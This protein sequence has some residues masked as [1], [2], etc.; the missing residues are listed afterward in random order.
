MVARLRWAGA[1]NKCIGDDTKAAARQSPNCINKQKWNKIWRKR[2]SIWRMEL[3][4][5]ATWHD[6]D[7]DFARWLH[8]FHLRI[9][10]ANTVRFLPRDAMQARPMPSCGVCVSVCVRHISYILSKRINISSIFV[11]HSSFSVTKQH[12]NIPTGTP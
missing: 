6:H 3:L 4:H 11:H 8:L 5:P 7:I 10:F 2:L 9:T 12:S 1:H